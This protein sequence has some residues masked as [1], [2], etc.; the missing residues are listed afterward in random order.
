MAERDH[1]QTGKPRKNGATGFVHT[2]HEFL[3][4][5]LR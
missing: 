4:F 5:C 3:H 2:W 1:Q